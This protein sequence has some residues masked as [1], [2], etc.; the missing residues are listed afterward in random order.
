MKKIFSLLLSALL[1]LSLVAC[2]NAAASTESAKT[3]T[4]TFMNNEDIVGTLSVE[5]GSDVTGFEA[6][7]NVDGFEFQGWFGAPTFIESSALDL[8]TATFDEDTTIFGSFK[9][10]AVAEDTRDWYIVGE[11]ASA[12]LQGSSWAGADVSDE[13]KANCKLTLTGNTTNEFAIT[14]DLFAGDKFQLITNWGWDTQ[15]GYGKVTECNDSEVESG[16][17]LSG[18]ASKANISVLVDGNYTITLTTDPDNS[19]QDTFVIVR[20]GDP[21]GAAAEVVTADNY[22]VNE[23]TGIVMK[24]SWIED[25]SENIELTRIDGSNIFEGSKELDADTELYFMVWDDGKDTGIGMNSSAVV[26]DDSKA[27]IDTEA[28]NVKVKE[29]ATYTFTVDA[30]TLTIKIS[31]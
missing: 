10:T 23:A 15:Y 12:V 18:E 19:K 4:L 5:A 25:W 28:N 1:A 21:L 31:K 9:S 17:G 22:V 7:E 20:N 14:L 30:D 13:D 16:G 3:V 6:F 2:G 24:G 29:A 27:L 8:S 11:G 26:D